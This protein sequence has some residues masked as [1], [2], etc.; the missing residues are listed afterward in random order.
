MVFHLC[1]VLILAPFQL[2]AKV[3]KHSKP[4]ITHKACDSILW[5]HGYRSLHIWMGCSG[6]VYNVI[7]LVNTIHLSLRLTDS[8][9]SWSICFPWEMSHNPLFTNIKPRSHENIAVFHLFFSPDILTLW[10]KENLPMSAL[11]EISQGDYENNKSLM[12]SF[13]Y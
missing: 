1:A 9:W 6:W 4:K 7:P 12:N 3:S 2:A 13:A 8:L 5:V 10:W 11:W